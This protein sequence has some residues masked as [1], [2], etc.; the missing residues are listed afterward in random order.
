MQTVQQALGIPIHHYVEVD[1]SGFK[2]LV[3]AI[4]GVE[5]CFDFPAQDVNTGLY[6]AEP[7]CDVLDGVQALAYAR[8]RHYEE[9]RDGEWH[10]D[11]TRRHRAH[12]APAAVR[13]RRAADGARP[14]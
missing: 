9:F 6:F 12:Q 3:D 2:D 13:Q 10:E 11:G 4:G 1:F 14:R 7:G 8:S 5:M